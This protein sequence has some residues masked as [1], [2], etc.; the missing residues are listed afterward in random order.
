MKA[1]TLVFSVNEAGTIVFTET[2]TCLLR[3]PKGEFQILPR[4][5]AEDLC[6]SIKD[7]GHDSHPVVGR[8]HRSWRAC[9]S[10]RLWD[11]TDLLHDDVFP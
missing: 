1:Y 11:S 7:V 6:R 3:K 10:R 9:P 2:V 5:N 8:D 4:A